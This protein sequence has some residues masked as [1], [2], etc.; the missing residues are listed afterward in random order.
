MKPTRHFAKVG[1]RQP[2]LHRERSGDRQDQPDDQGLDVAKAAVLQVEDDEHV[3]RGET[4]A[5]DKRQAEQQVE[6]DGR[7]DDLSEIAGGDGDLAE[8]PQQDGGPARVAVAARLGEVASAGDAK[9]ARQGPAAG[10][11]SGWRS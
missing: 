10:S 1:L 5:P 6:R 9:P 4:D 11:P 8:Q 7:A 2:Q 3:E